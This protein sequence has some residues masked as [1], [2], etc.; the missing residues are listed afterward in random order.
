MLQ[1][2]LVTDA[3]PRGYDA[4]LVEATLSP[5]EEGVALDVAVVLNGNVLVVALGGAG[6]LED[7]RVVDDQLD[8]DQWVD[9]GRV[10]TEGDDGV[11]HRSEVHDRGDASEVLHQNALGGEGNFRRVVARGLA[12]ARRGLGPA[13][14]RLDVRR[15]DL[16][17]VFVAQQ[18]LQ[19]DL[20]GVGQAVNGEL[21]EPARA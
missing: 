17:A 7:H 16:D 15:G 2:D 5:L 9:L 21:A 18:V 4:E 1:V 10:A 13:R 3:H 14:Q 6:A 19:Q 11:T 12:V 20:D 8:R